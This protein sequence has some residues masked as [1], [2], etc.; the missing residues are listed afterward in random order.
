MLAYV[1]V[2]KA[3]DVSNLRV[4]W[5][6]LHKAM[7]TGRPGSQGNRRHMWFRNYLLRVCASCDICYVRSSERLKKLVYVLIVHLLFLV[8]SNT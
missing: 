8:S 5:G 6:Q 4:K 7:N 1:P 3:S 2:T